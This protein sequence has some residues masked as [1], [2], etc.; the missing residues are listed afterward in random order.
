MANID[1]LKE[2]D[3]PKKQFKG[4]YKKM[5]KKNDSEEKNGS[6]LTIDIRENNLKNNKSEPTTRKM[7]DWFFGL[8]N[9]LFS[10]SKK[11]N[12]ENKTTDTS[13]NN[14]IQQSS[15]NNSN[16]QNLKGLTFK[17]GRS[18]SNYNDNKNQKIQPKPADPGEKDKNKEVAE[19]ERGK[20]ES[21]NVIKTNLIESQT[22]VFFEWKPKIILLILF[23]IITFFILGMIYGGLLYWELQITSQQEKMRGEI[24]LLQKEIDT[25]MKNIDY[26][27]SFQKQLN[28][29]SAKLKDHVY[30]TNFFKFLEKNT[31]KDIYYVDGFNGNTD[32]KY[33]LKAVTNNFE[34]LYNQIELFKLNKEV[35]N[36][37]TGGGKIEGKEKIVSGENLI[38]FSLDLVVDPKIFSNSQ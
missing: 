12:Y 5:P 19:K 31:L 11:I 24:D 30:W 25:T 34:N 4:D 2:E 29:S 13:K 27:T 21:S 7:S 3:K 15:L 32:G 16:P 8:K 9:K 37:N 1:F 10:K 33:A 6:K 14:N 36:V 20:Y 17:E 35:S 38:N 18:D 23:S 22:L 28:L 26:I